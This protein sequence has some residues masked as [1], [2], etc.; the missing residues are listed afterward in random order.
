MHLFCPSKLSSSANNIAEEE[1]VYWKPIT[2]YDYEVERNEYN[3]S[4]RVIDS[5]Q[6]SVAVDNLRVLL[7]TE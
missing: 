2:Y 5:N 7:E 1:L 4:I 6:A 3:K